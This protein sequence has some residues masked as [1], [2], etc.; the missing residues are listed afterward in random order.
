MPAIS[1]RLKLLSLVLLVL[2]S[3]SGLRLYQHYS[4]P[5]LPFPKPDNQTKL[6]PQLQHYL[7]NILQQVQSRGR[8]PE[9]HA[10]VA[11]AYAANGLWPE[12]GRA[13]SNVFQLNPHQPLA[14]MY[15]GVAL[16][17]TGQPA[18][19]YAVFEKLTQRFPQFPQGYYR[20]GEMA[21]KLGKLDVAKSAFQRLIALAPTEWRGHSGLGE[22]CFRQGLY[23]EAA[24]H[25]H[26]SVG[27]EWNANKAHHL[28]GLTYRALGRTNEATVEL[29]LGMNAA[30]YAMPDDWS[31]KAFEHMRLLQDQLEM[32]ETL[33]QEG[34]FEKAVA[35]LTPL[36]AF[37][38]QNVSLLNNLAIALNRAGRP[39]Q[40]KPLILKAIEVQPDFLPAYITLS[41]ICQALDERS[42][43][44]RHAEKAISM[45][46]NLSQGYVA[47][48]NALLAMEKDAE[49]IAALE[50][51]LS[52]EP[53]NA[54]LMIEIGDVYLRNLNQPQE[55]LARYRGAA[56]ANPGLWLPHFRLAEVLAGTGD[57]NGALRAVEEVLRLSPRNP[58]ALE[59]K[60]EL[61][62]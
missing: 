19:A 39:A 6:E 61:Q 32:A 13:F 57:T 30:T 8:D 21:L 15:T 46:P 55:A 40:A 59:F 60:K 16:E 24:R 25:L 48:A 56:Q 18:E 38:P 54:E 52:V 3:W 5:A 17:E 14:L 49:A 20:L 33:A 62:K 35:Q 37:H 22:V 12:A 11:L 51:A 4:K 2:V 10:T 7:S 34:E 23:E 47:K 29:A 44:L 28:L 45:G 27:L 53:Q 41:F 43:A 36:L 58:A 1:P 26:Q 31:G 9:A 50:K 42:E